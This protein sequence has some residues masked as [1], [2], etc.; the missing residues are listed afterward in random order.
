MD[1]KLRLRF[2]TAFAGEMK[3]AFPEYVAVKLK[4][5]YVWPGESLWRKDTE[6]CSYFIVLSPHPKGEK[7]EMTVELGWSRRKRFPEL[8]QRPSIVTKEGV[9]TAAE[10]DEGSVRIGN[11]CANAFDWTQVKDATIQDIVS[12]FI[13][14]LEQ[15]GLPFLCRIGN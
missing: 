4:S 1:K 15:E 11:L 8:M 5:I 13:L 2:T 9:S 10:R 3:K 6:D 14:K 7:D 12:F